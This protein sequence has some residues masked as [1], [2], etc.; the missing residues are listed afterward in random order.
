MQPSVQALDGEF[1]FIY[2]RGMAHEHTHSV[3]EKDANSQLDAF[4]SRVLS[5]S[6]QGA[7]R[8]I[9]EGSVMV[10]GRARPPHCKLAPGAQVV[11]KQTDAGLY[12]PLFALAAATRDYCAFVKPSGLH[13]ARIM[14]SG[15]PSLEQSL[16]SLWGASQGIPRIPVNA[17]AAPPGLLDALGGPEPTHGI[18]PDAL[19]PEPPTLLS[20]LDAATSGLVA[21]AFT[22]DAAKRFRDLEAA[23][24]VDKYYLAL[25]QGAVPGPFRVTNALDTDNRK[26][27]RVLAETSP[28]PTRHNEIVP[29]PEDGMAHAAAHGKTTLVSVHI[30]RGARHQIRAHL[31]HAGFPLVGDALYGSA[32]AETPL[33]LHHA[34][35]L[36]PGFSAFHL[37]SW[38]S[39]L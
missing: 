32:A 31:A 1:K 7:K 20:R 22:E 2:V 5:C 26:K 28:D 37:P 17:T 13:T 9:L 12:P 23:G 16:A 19:P 4:V 3:P 6:A 14:G 24:K 18:S 34:R 39:I 38:L 29:M 25:V 33:H 15:E 27:T 11:V 10:D 36:L 35:L 21:A 8:L 30:K